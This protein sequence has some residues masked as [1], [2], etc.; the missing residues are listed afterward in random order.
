M[1]ENISALD[2]SAL[3]ASTRDVVRRSNEL[4]AELLIHLA[5]V[6]S[7]GLYRDQ[8]FPT[9]FAYCMGELG[10]SEDVTYNVTT[11][12][13]LAKQFPELLTGLREGR[14][15]LS[16]L[17]LLAPHF[18]EKGS[19]D[20]IARAWGR[21]K[22]EIEGLIAHINPQPDVPDSVRKLPAPR[23]PNAPAP[24]TPALDLFSSP[25][26]SS[27][28]ATASSPQVAAPPPAPEMSAAPVSAPPLASAPKRIDRV[29]PLA[30]STYKIEFTAGEPLQQKLQEAQALLRHRRPDGSLAFIF[31]EA[32]DLLIAKV[33]KQRFGIGAKPR[34]TPAP[35]PPHQEEKKTPK[36]PSPHIPY[37]MRREVVGR[38]TL[39][40]SFVGPDGRRCS[41]TAYLEF[42]HV[43]GF[44]RTGQH[45]VDELRVYCKAHN[46]LAAEKLYGRDFMKRRRETARLRTAEQPRHERS[47][48]DAGATSRPGTAETAAHETSCS[49]SAPVSRPETAEQPTHEPSRSESAPA[50]RPGTA[51]QPT[52]ETSCSESAPVSRPG[53]A[54]Q[55]T[56]EP[57][58]SESA[59]ASR[60]GTAEQPTHEPS[61]PSPEITLP[62][63]DG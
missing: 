35:K 62:F 63:R 52:H 51:E 23:A 15:H 8:A 5:E 32:I 61:R 42:D 37:G 4:T 47:R 1:T 43:K 27:L 18:K 12:A 34:P 45:C 11:V 59:P 20:L 26:P 24:E 2:N 31:E 44:A 29:K 9:L 19:D 39:R 36:L 16:G 58:R 6:E 21:T 13:R 41:E 56:H 50:S 28:S 40:C 25:A 60:P 22:R 7:R 3:L 53:T 46:L 55:P 10:L 33:K 57:S 48:S 17:R 38:D 54:E 49:E 30:P 14:L